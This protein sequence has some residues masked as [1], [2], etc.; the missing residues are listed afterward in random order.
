MQLS[1]EMPRCFI[2]QERKYD[3]KGEEEHLYFILERMDYD[4]EANK[5]MGH[6]TSPS[7]WGTFSTVLTVSIAS[8][9]TFTMTN[10]EGSFRGHGNLYGPIDNW[11]IMKFLDPRIAQRNEGFTGVY[12]FGENEISAQKRFFDLET[13]QNKYFTV[14]RGF[15][16]SPEQFEAL[17][18]DSSSIPQAF[19]ELR[20]K[21]VIV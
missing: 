7:S 9:D 15:Y 5:I 10:Q 19:N 2:A 17:Q 4:K 6:A 1:R 11:T 12:S 3:L 8:D 21:S 18:K 16:I 14:Q 20:V 13:Q